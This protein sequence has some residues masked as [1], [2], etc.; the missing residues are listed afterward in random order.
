MVKE[1]GNTKS[2]SKKK[3]TVQAIKTIRERA[4]VYRDLKKS[5]IR[6]Q[7]ATQ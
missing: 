7:E 5:E 3:T 1:A 6:T 2:I 4:F